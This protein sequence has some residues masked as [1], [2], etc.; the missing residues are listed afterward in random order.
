MR[1]YGEV[2]LEEQQY[3]GVVR[4]F[5]AM[6]SGHGPQDVTALPNDLAEYLLGMHREYCLARGKQS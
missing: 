5:E 1:V 2:E 4:L 3:Y 6:L